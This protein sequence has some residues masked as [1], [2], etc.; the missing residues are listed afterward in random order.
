M[1]KVRNERRRRL[2]Y[3]DQQAYESQLDY[4]GNLNLKKQIYFQHRG[5]D[6][7]KLYNTTEMAKKSLVQSPNKKLN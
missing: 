6:S 5:E 4:K 3:G 7:L 1:M 2:T